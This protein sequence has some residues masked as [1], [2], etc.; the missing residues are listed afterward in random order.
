MK[1]RIAQN[2]TQV[3][4]LHVLDTKLTEKLKT[5]KKHKVQ[6]T[7]QVGKVKDFEHIFD[8]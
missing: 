5:D 4:G 2:R 8:R 1:T 6:L 7:S 3:P